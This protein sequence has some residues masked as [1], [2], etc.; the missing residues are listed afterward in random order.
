VQLFDATGDEALSAFTQIYLGRLATMRGDHSAAVAALERGRD[1]ANELGLL[2]LADLIMTDLGDALALDGQLERARVVLSAADRGGKL[3]FLPG[4]GASLVALA[5]LERREGNVASAIE[6]ATEALALVIA[7]NNRHGIAQC[8]AILGFLAETEGSVDDALSHHMRA[9]SYATETNEARSVALALEGLA[10]VA[11][12]ERD[13]RRA[14]RLLGAAEALRGATTW[15]VGWWVA[16]AEIGDVDRISR[17]AITEIGSAAFAD[18]F[19]MGAADV[20]AVLADIRAP[21]R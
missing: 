5:L 14:A 19:E 12:R 9:L 21:Q 6:A 10:G 17:A 7:S 2:G 1:I 8:L 16:S 13:G 3:V 11:A 18:A 20:E 15:R 4:H